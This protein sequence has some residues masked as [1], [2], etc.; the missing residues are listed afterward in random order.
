MHDDGSGVV[1]VSTVLDGDAVKSAEA[2]GGKLEARVRTADLSG[3]GWTVQPWVRKPDGSARLVLRKPFA[4][5]AQLAAIIGEVSGRAGPLRDVGLTRDHG[6]LST[7]YR[8][9]GRIDLGAMGTGVTADPAVAAALAN[10]KVDVAALDRTLLAQLR[11][12]VGVRVVV[13]T[14]GGI[15]TIVGKPG[16]AVPI[17]A[18]GSV[19]DTQRVALLATAVVLVLVAIVVLLWPRRRAQRRTATGAT[20]SRAT[21]TTARATPGSPGAS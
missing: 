2:A 20:R 5:P 21:P 14:P 12:S 18:S 17:D 10:Q 8:V 3:S 1:T 7:D 9:H 4:S 13:Q 16:T 19:T 11:Q 15:T 6:L